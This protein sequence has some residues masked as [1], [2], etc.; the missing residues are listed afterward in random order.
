MAD[1]ETNLRVLHELAALGLRV[2][3]D[4][5]YS[6]LAQLTRL[7]VAVLKIDRAFVDGIE[8]ASENRTVVRAIIGT[9]MCKSSLN[10]PPTSGFLPTGG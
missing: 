4:D 10:L 9:S 1:V 6:S 3:V 7:P 2:A 8:K 5:G